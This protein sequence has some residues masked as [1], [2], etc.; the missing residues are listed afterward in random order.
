MGC[1]SFFSTLLS[2]SLLLCIHRI[3]GSLLCTSWTA[4][5]LS[6]LCL[7][8]LMALSLSPAL[9]E[10]SKKKAAKTYKFALLIGNNLGDQKSIPLKYAQRDAR[11][12]KQVLIQLG[13]YQAG[14]VHLLLGHSASTVRKRMRR[15]SRLI[16]EIRKRRDPLIKIILFFYYSGHARQGN[17]LLGKSKLSFQAIKSFMKRSKASLKLAVFDACESGSLAKTRGL[18]RVQKSFRFPVVNLTPSASGEVVITAT[19]ANENAHE[20]SRLQ[21]GVF[22]HYF[23]LGLRGAADKNTDGHVTLEEV[24]TYSYN[25]SLERSI[26][27]HHGPQRARFSKRLSG[28]GSLILTR[29]SSQRSWLLLEAK[30]EGGFFVWNQKRDLLLAEFNKHAGQ[31]LR[32]ALSPGRYIVQWRQ[33]KKVLV[34][35]IRLQKNHILRLKASGKS[36]QYWKKGRVRGGFG[37]HTTLRHAVRT[38]E[39]HKALAFSYG[40]GLSQFHEQVFHQGFSLYTETLIGKASLASA[41]LRMGYQFGQVLVI[42]RLQY[43]LH[44]LEL[45]TGLLWHFLQIKGFRMSLG[46]LGRLS[47]IIQD[48]HPFQGRSSDTLL[49]FAGTLSGVLQMRLLLFRNFFAQLQGSGGMRLIKLGGK[50]D[51]HLDI[52]TGLALGFLF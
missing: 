51:L 27:S 40:L 39:K 22:T 29:L 20:D 30:L 7:L 10:A 24:Y 11:K 17:L 44:I 43:S 18:K 52:R 9:G 48:I 50:M 19:G 12:V 5:L 32:L 42:Q 46:L 38:G 28:Y 34:R 1:F 15:L 41:F 16:R 13:G 36:M 33:K 37:R 47:G 4:R 26:F 49:S 21:G 14:D 35:P 45:E 3:K 23:L 2:C 8:P 31:A 6:P 25:R